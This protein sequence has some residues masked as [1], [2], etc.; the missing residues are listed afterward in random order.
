[1]EQLDNNTKRQLYRQ[2]CREADELLKK[3]SPCYIHQGRC[4]RT[5][6]YSNREM[7]CKHCV[8][9]RDTGCTVRSLVCKLWLCDE[10]IEVVDKKFIDKAK[11]IF[12]RA[13]KYDLVMFRAC[14][15]DVIYGFKFNGK[16]SNR[17]EVKMPWGTVYFIDSAQNTDDC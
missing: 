2:L 16:G 11:N 3:L 7:C 15:D 8:Y 4:Y 13:L 5:L 9:L 14:E 1:M 10:V 6:F 12:E 17:A